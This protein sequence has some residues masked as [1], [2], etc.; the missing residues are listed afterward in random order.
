[1][2][3]STQSA[4]G[5]VVTNAK[6]SESAQTD[7]LPDGV[8]ADQASVPTKQLGPQGGLAPSNENEGPV[9][10]PTHETN[11]AR[12]DGNFALKPTLTQAEGAKLLHSVV[13][14]ADWLR[15]GQ[16]DGS[17]ALI[18]AVPF[19]VNGASYW[20]I[21]AAPANGDYT[22][23]EVI[24]SINRP[25]QE[26]LQQKYGQNQQTPEERQW[27]AEAKQALGDNYSQASGETIAADTP[28]AAFDRTLAPRAATAVISLPFVNPQ[29]VS[30]NAIYQLS[31]GVYKLTEVVSGTYDMQT[32]L[33]NK[34]I[35]GS[36]N[37]EGQRAKA[38][39]E[40]MVR[41]TLL[42]DVI[43]N[44]YDV[45]HPG[46]TIDERAAGV[47]G[48]YLDLLFFTLGPEA[49]PRGTTGRSLPPSLEIPRRTAGE[50]VGANRAGANL[51]E[52]RVTR[53]AESNLDG[54]RTQVTIRPRL[55]NGQLA[56]YTVRVDD[57]GRNRTTGAIE[58]IDA[59]SS[60]TAGL[61]TNQTKG[62]PLIERNGG[63][64]V[65]DNGGARYPNGFVIP[66]TR[67]QFITPRVLPGNAP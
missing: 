29:G 12:T 37:A 60:D 1:M 23:Q 48:L 49:V 53:W 18:L 10:R 39:A 14:A 33:H 50:V 65:A 16:R 64:V 27:L 42:G 56:D 15:L 58:L 7:Q 19:K 17:N 30:L 2:I 44:V 36:I 31:G 20:A 24:P 61:T 21:Y 67:V 63:V 34:Y 57:L 3:P 52:A 25:I 62:Y 40:F 22:L 46:S 13:G 43:L 11:D 41:A 51:F 38:A 32:Y 5:S 28:G 26:Y 47:G 35:L 55:D 66:R 45:A 54:V 9:E 6:Y 4:N 59:K 8:A